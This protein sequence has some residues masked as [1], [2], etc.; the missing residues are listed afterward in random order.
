MAVG[1]AAGSGAANSI[2]QS[3]GVSIGLAS[4]LGVAFGFGASSTL[5]VGNATGLGVAFA[6]AEMG[7][8][9]SVRAF[10]TEYSAVATITEHD[11]AVSLIEDYEGR[12]RITA[13]N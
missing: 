10:V 8:V 5:S 1:V 7:I 11:A 6:F 2:G 4:G 12:I 13:S 9:V 3:S